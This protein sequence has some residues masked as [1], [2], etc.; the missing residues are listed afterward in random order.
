MHRLILP[1]VALLFAGCATF[2]EREL[3]YMQRSGVPA[4]LLAKLDRGVQLTPPEIIT[5]SRYNV[6]DDFIIRHLQD[7]G[8]EYLVT[9]QDITRMRNAGVSA[10]V[11]DVLIAE[12]ERF[13]W[14]Y[15][16][17]PVAVDAGFWWVDSPYFGPDL[18]WDM[19]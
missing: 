17:P 12:C 18:Y 16:A 2:T 19:W 13:A 1:A 11:I 7:N 6:P 9:R 5:L 15:S 4:P 3:A 10:R 8:V 14:R